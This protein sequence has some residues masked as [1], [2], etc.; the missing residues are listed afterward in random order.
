MHWIVRL[1]DSNFPQNHRFSAGRHKINREI[2]FS[3]LSYS[4]I[5]WAPVRLMVTQF[6]PTISIISKSFRLST[7]QRRQ[8]STISL[9]Y[10]I[11]IEL[12]HQNGPSHNAWKWTIRRELSNYSV[13][14]C[15]SRTS[16]SPLE[17][18][19]PLQLSLKS[20]MVAPGRFRL[21]PRI[22]WMPSFC[23]LKILLSNENHS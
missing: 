15:G 11:V 10:V 13:R 1:Q 23:C 19:F 9:T 12:A 22:A 4:Q 20:R 18:H 8:A 21:Y 7:P 14:G 2:S 16:E 5:V 6:N 3:D 17:Y